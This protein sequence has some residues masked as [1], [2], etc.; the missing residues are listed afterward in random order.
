MTDQANGFS[1]ATALFLIT[2]VGTAEFMRLFADAHEGQESIIP[3]DEFLTDEPPSAA[4]D[5][6][7]DVFAE[8]HK[9]SLMNFYY[10]YGS[11]FSPEAILKTLD[12]L[13]GLDISGSL[14]N[15]VLGQAQ[16]MVQSPTKSTTNTSE[17]TPDPVYGGNNN[18]I[19]GSALDALTATDETETL[20]AVPDKE[21]DK[22]VWEDQKTELQ[23][24][25]ELGLLDEG[26][27]D[28]H[29]Q[30]YYDHDISADPSSEEKDLC[31][32]CQELFG[33]ATCHFCTEDEGTSV[34]LC[35]EHFLY[36]KP[37]E[38]ELP[39]SCCFSCLCKFGK[40]KIVGLD[41][42]EDLASRRPSY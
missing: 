23:L 41:D 7:Y 39:L 40:S 16:K 27:D 36:V 15:D 4:R 31:R 1:R 5:E 25:R 21:D 12:R 29:E 11:L 20:M 17:I 32:V 14:T 26:Q 33:E 42:P 6:L 30:D 38:S 2:Q 22:S 3:A 18:N 34:W 8:Q 13:G 24:A 37:T 35:S 10:T 9:R 19:T 28:Y